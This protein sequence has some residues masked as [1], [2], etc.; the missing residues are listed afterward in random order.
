[1]IFP[2]KSKEGEWF[3]PAFLVET[4]VTY[5]MWVDFEKKWVDEHNSKKSTLQI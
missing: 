4:T 3:L 5:L 1:M 2:E